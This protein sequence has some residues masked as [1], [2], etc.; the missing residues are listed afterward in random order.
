[1]GSGRG[2]GYGVIIEAGCDMV[3]FVTFAVL[4]SAC[5]LVNSRQLLFND[6]LVSL[7]HMCRN[8]VALDKHPLQ[9]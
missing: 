9:V 7:L 6:W 4:D 2:E 5:R 8:E 3:R 1:M